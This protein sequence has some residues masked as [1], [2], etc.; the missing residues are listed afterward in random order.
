[1]VMRLIKPTSTNT[2]PPTRRTTP[3]KIQNPTIARIGTVDLA[4]A[5]GIAALGVPSVKATTLVTA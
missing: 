5:V 2:V 3:P 4:T 1:M